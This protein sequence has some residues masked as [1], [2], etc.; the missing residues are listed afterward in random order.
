MH[1]YVCIHA[2]MHNIIHKQLLDVYYSYFYYKW[3]YN[4]FVKLF[5]IMKHL[6]KLLK[7]KTLI[8]IKQ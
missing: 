1:V 2:C 4:M 3:D 7:Y 8:F 5:S 6:A